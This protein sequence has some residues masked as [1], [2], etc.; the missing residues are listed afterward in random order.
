MAPVS[1]A[2][3]SCGTK[4]GATTPR[5]SSLSRTG[6]QPRA[7]REFSGGTDGVA[8][9]LHRLEFE[10]SFIDDNDTERPPLGGWREAST[11]GGEAARAAWAEAARHVLLVV[12]SR[13]RVV[14]TYKELSHEVQRRT[15]V[16]TN[17]LM[18]YWIGDVLSRVATECARRGEPL[19]SALC[20]N[21]AGS[22]GDG[23]AVAVRN[24]SGETPGD[25]DDHAAHERLRCYRYFKAA[26]LPADGGTPALTP[27][28]AASRSRYLKRTASP[29][30]TTCPRCHTQLPATGVCDYCS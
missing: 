10:V 17:Q 29:P 14:V 16:R 8:R 12:A 27:K 11:V 21:A 25:P 13:Y 20:V 2:S 18:H 22:V 15:G 9:I 7:P 23:Y 24:T 30:V 5:R 26:G 4:G 6:V 3:T 19:L 1:P 28:L